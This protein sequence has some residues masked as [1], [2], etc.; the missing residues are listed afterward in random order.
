M[1][2]TLLS[3]SLVALKEIIEGDIPFRIAIKNLSRNDKK[4]TPE[5]LGGVS[6][7]LGANLRHY[8]L[9]EELLK[10]EFEELAGDDRYLMSIF[11]SDTLFSKKLIFDDIEKELSEALS[12]KELD[13]KSIYFKYSSFDSIAFFKKDKDE[14]KI[15]N[16][17]FLS[18]RY[19]TPTWLIKMWDKHFPKSLLGILKKNIVVSDTSL[20]INTKRIS[21]EEVLA[22]NPAFSK[23]LAFDDM[24]LYKGKKAKNLEL[25]LNNTLYPLRESERAIFEDINIDDGDKIIIYSEQGGNNLYHKVR[26]LINATNWVKF[27]TTSYE[28]YRKARNF[29]AQENEREQKTRNNFVTYRTERKDMCTCLLSNAKYVDEDKKDEEKLNDYF[30]LLP[31]SSNFDEIRHSPDYLLHFKKDKLDELINNQK[32]LILEAKE[33]LRVGGKIIYAVPTLNNKEGRILINGILREN[34]DLALVKDRQFF[35]YSDEYHSSL[36]FAILEK[37]GLEETNDESL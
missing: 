9:L 13:L 10:R 14:G 16:F 29:I 1:A 18:I 5:L 4:I 30:F 36:Y 26:E 35:P 20:A 34:A 32:S 19:N 31:D 7:I 22:S 11:L 6:A 12:N 33:Y 17:E 28:D 37:K 3:L 15:S 27:L 24:V 8:F 25:V 23:S 2:Q 21:L